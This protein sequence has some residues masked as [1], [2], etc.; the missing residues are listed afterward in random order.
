MRILCNQE[1][2]DKRAKVE[3][4]PYNDFAKGPTS[5]LALLHTIVIT[6]KK[7]QSLHW[8]FCRADSEIDNE[9]GPMKY[10]KRVEIGHLVYYHEKEIGLLVKKSQ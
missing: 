9:I 2:F 10:S 1:H 5:M 7:G 8:P 3:I 4:G 6:R